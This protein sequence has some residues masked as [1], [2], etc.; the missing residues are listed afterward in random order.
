MVSSGTCFDSDEFFLRYVPDLFLK[1]IEESMADDSLEINCGEWLQKE[2]LRERFGKK[3]RRT[4]LRIQERGFFEFDAV[5]ESHSIVANFLL[6]GP[7]ADKK[8]SGHSKKLKLRAD[9]LMLL[10]IRADT[11]LM[12]FTEK[13]VHKMAIREQDEGRLP[14]SVKFL[15]AEVPVRKSAVKKSVVPEQP[16]DLFA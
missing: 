8:L 7:C 4:K 6:S 14:L 11:K 3:F 5:D 10:L 16:E 12:I 1:I 2:W 13:S 9:C 15:Y